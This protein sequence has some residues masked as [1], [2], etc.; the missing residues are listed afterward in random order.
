MRWLVGGIPDDAQKYVR[1][2]RCQIDEQLRT[3]RLARFS[4]YDADGATHRQPLV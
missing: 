3:S 4:E 2:T 1:A